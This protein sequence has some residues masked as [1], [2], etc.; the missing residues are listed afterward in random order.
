MS[1]NIRINLFQFL[2][3]LKDFN[4]IFVQSILQKCWKWPVPQYDFSTS[5]CYRGQKSQTIIKKTYTCIK[6]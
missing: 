3:F 2:L 5:T 4:H 6:P 1:H